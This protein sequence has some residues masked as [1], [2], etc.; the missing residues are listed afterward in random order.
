MFT[1]I[2]IHLRSNFC[3]RFC[4][5]LRIG[6]QGRCSSLGLRI[7]SNRRSHNAAV[8]VPCDCPLC[9]CYLC[10]ECSCGEE[11]PARYQPKGLRR[12]CS[13]TWRW[14]WRGCLGQLPGLCAAARGEPSCAQCEGLRYKHQGDGLLARTLRGLLL[15]PGDRWQV[16]HW[17]ALHDVRL[18]EPGA[19]GNVPSIPELHDR[20]VLSA[21]PDFMSCD[22]GWKQK[23]HVQQTCLATNTH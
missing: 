3:P 9:A 17:H 13:C 7:A 18:V 21:M 23:K 6:L 16:R 5:S 12:K 20:A 11:V 19:A 1:P 22:V 8:P 14:C 4:A 15:P 10:D 2:C